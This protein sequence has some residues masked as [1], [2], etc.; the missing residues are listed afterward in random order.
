MEDF[1][2]APCHHE[3]QQTEHE[4]SDDAIKLLEHSDVDQHH[5]NHGQREQRQRC[6]ANCRRAPDETDRG[7]HR[8]ID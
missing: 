3:Q 5:L 6:P 7:K 2:I 1:V 4:E 8:S